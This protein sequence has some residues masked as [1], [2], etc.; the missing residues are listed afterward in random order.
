MTW[1]TGLLLLA[2]GYMAG[3]LSVLI[4]IANRQFEDWLR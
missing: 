2:A 3:A 4:Y 1:F